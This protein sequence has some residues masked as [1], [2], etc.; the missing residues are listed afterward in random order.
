MAPGPIADTEG[1]SRLGELS[2]F[3]SGPFRCS[4]FV[5]CL[6]GLAET[7]NNIFIVFMEYLR[8]VVSAS[9]STSA[10]FKSR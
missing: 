5:C 10:Q 9:N 4:D 8:D 6:L 2:L 3:H 1:M 7:G